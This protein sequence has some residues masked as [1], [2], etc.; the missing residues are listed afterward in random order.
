MYQHL[1]M[2]VCTDTL[3]TIFCTRKTFLSPTWN[4][5]NTWATFP[6]FNKFS[7]YALPQ[8]KIKNFV[9]CFWNV[10]DKK[11][12]LLRRKNMWNLIGSEECSSH[13]RTVCHELNI[14]VR[15]KTESAPLIYITVFSE[16]H[17]LIKNQKLR[18]LKQCNS[19]N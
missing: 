9:N 17:S 14:V 10:T 11:R 2:H 19:V 16:K 12:A 6:R 4:D 15:L 7:I 3:C 5:E 1:W 8:S 18:W 13:C